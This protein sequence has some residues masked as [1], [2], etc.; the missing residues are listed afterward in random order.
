LWWYGELVGKDKRR[1][2]FPVN[3]VE[4]VDPKVKRDLAAVIAASTDPALASGG[5]GRAAAAPAG[6]GGKKP[7]YIFYSSFLAPQKTENLLA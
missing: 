3:F 1:G 5:G 6:R 7:G 2:M 4:A